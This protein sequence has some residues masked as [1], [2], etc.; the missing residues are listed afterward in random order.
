M[1]TTG[2]AE[3]VFSMIDQFSRTILTNISIK[4]GLDA[5]Y[6]LPI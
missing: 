2:T 6:E 1:G 5:T 4:G 3:Q